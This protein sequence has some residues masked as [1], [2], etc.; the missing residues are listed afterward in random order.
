M[1]SVLQF[2]SIVVPTSNLETREVC[3]TADTL[4]LLRI[5]G[6]DIRR[7]VAILVDIVNIYAE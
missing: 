5:Q 3:L 2:L 7:K 1:I 6:A 4:P